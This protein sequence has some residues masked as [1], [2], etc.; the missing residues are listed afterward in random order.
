[1]KT[2]PANQLHFFHDSLTIFMIGVCLVIC[3]LGITIK[4]SRLK[5]Y[6]SYGLISFA[7]MQEILDYLN[8]IFFD[9]AVLI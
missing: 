3:Y 8:R 4:D 6:I 9:E 7:I 1:M 5:T 2:L